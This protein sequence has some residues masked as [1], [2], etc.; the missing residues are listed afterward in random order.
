LL[1]VTA[2]YTYRIDLMDMDI[3]VPE[4]LFQLDDEGDTLLTSGGDKIPI[5]VL[6]TILK[7]I[8][9]GENFVAVLEFA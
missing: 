8:M 3:E 2:C 7:H 1:V 5:L 4:I 9:A 6:D